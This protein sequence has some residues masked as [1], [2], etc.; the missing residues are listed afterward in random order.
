MENGAVYA[1][2]HNKHK[3]KLYGEIL[4]VFEEKKEGKRSNQVG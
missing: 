3:N 2:H 4:G 1:L